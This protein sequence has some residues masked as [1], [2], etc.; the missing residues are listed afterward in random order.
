MI[1][2]SWDA[3]SSSGK[4]ASRVTGL[5]GR[6]AAADGGNPS[7]KASSNDDEKRPSRLPRHPPVPPHIDDEPRMIE[8]PQTDLAQ[9]I[10]DQLRCT[11]DQL[12]DVLDAVRG[13]GALGFEVVAITDRLDEV[14]KQF[15]DG[16]LFGLGTE[17]LD[18]SD[19]LRQR[20]PRRGA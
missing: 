7:A 18:E 8:R 17:A 1:G 15:I 16:R 5:P 2:A 20:G 9:L 4:N 13:L 19:E 14:T 10:G 6:R 3:F 11:G 12:V